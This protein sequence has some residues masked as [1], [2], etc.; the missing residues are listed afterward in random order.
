MSPT[1]PC[2]FVESVQ[3]CRSPNRVPT[4]QGLTC[5]LMPPPQ[6]PED[7]VLCVAMRAMF[8]SSQGS[9]LVRGA[10]ARL[11]TTHLILF[12]VFF[13]ESKL[14]CSRS[15]GAIYQ[16]VYQIHPRCASNFHLSGDTP[17]HLYFPH[18]LDNGWYL[19]AFLGISGTL[20]RRLLCSSKPPYWHL[21][22]GL[23]FSTQCC[24]FSLCGS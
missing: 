21:P 5:L 4:P 2:T 18:H 23:G 12:I 20:L 10:R 8:S 24:H 16:L 19:G 6:A 14:L 11:R 15:G 9:T 22:V 1:M 7:P 13:C 3:L 17:V